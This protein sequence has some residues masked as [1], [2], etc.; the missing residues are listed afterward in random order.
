MGNWVFEIK[1]VHVHVYVHLTDFCIPVH[2]HVYSC[3]CT[4]YTHYLLSNLKSIQV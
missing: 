4:L 2:V 3:E 1:H